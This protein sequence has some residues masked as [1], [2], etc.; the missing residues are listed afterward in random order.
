MKAVQG[1]ELAQTDER[2]FEKRLGNALLRIVC[3]CV[4]SISLR[5]QLSIAAT[6]TA[7][8]SRNCRYVGWG[9]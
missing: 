5:T 2:E 7:D 8:A 1:R 9:L 6:R 4:Y 3:R